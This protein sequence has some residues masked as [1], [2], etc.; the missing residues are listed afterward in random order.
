[1]TRTDAGRVW[2]NFCGKPKE[3]V[4]DMIES[5]ELHICSECV[6]RAAELIAERESERTAARLAE[7]LARPPVSEGAPA[8]MQR[9]E[10]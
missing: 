9:E 6:E 1:M 3:N 7:A 5:H 4:R 2:C 10:V 8:D